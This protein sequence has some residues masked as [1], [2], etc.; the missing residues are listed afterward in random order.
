MGK[1][2]T[3]DVVNLDF[4]NFDTDFHILIKFNKGEGKVL[5]LS[6]NSSMCQYTLENVWKVA[7]KWGLGGPQVTH[8]SAINPSSKE[9][10]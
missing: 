10:Q 8:D 1:V 9:G 3:V 5:H 7:F 2:E 4:S 6:K